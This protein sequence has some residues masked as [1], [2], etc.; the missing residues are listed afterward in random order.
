MVQTIYDI[1]KVYGGVQLAIW[2]KVEALSA[3][4]AAQAGKEGQGTEFIIWL[5]V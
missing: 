3:D 4:A 2:L 5:P 1:V